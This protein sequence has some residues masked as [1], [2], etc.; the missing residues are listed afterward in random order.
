[1]AILCSLKYSSNE[2]NF[3]LESGFFRAPYVTFVKR[4]SV[5]AGSV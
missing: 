4:S 5:M 1:M 2:D 3:V